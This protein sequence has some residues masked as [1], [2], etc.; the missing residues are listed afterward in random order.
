MSYR[1]T[2]NLAETITAHNKT[3]LKSKYIVQSNKC[4][5]RTQKCPMD[6]K[7]L[8]KNII[9]QAKITEKIS[10]KVETY[11]GRTST[12]FKER[13]GNHK[14]SFK[15]E[16]LINN[17]EL[18]KHIWSLKNKNIEIEEIKWKILGR[19]SPYS[20]TSNVCN[21]CV[22]EKYFILYEPEK[23]TLNKRTELTANCRHKTKSLLMKN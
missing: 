9:Y 14:S 12:T 15:H 1:T 19:G 3:L 13:Y 22:K 8:E 6:G 18:A 2:P 4:N 10:K 11:I 5:C 16:H 17:C 23:G 21:L 20:P 7:C